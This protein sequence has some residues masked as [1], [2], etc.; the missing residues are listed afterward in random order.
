V[1]NTRIFIIVAIISNLTFSV[2]L[3]LT[4]NKNMQLNR[5]SS[6]D[7]Q[8]LRKRPCDIGAMKNVV[9]SVEYDRTLK[10]SECIVNSNMVVYNHISDPETLVRIITYKGCRNETID[11]YF[12]K[13]DSE[14][15]SFASYTLPSGFQ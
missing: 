3:Y 10:V 15:I 6:D 11:I 8:F 13:I 2:V 4:S 9:S 12:K 5:P 1:S 7:S 14:W